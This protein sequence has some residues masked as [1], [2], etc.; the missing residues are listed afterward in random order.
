MTSEINYFYLF[1]LLLRHNVFLYHCFISH[2]LCDLL[3]AI[4]VL[5]ALMNYKVINAFLL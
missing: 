2:L 3:D 1:A 4:K 5:T